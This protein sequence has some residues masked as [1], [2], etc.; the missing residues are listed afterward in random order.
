MPQKKKHMS[1]KK[2]YTPSKK[3]KVSFVKSKSKMKKMSSKKSVKTSS[4]RHV[5]YKKPSRFDAAMKRAYSGAKSGAD[6]GGKLFGPKGAVIGGA[7]GGFVN[8]AYGAI[9]GQGTYKIS[10][11]TLALPGQQVPSFEH[12]NGGVIIRHREYILDI[13]TTQN[14]QSLTYNINAG[15][16]TLFPWL[17]TIANQFELYEFKG[18][19]FDARTTSGVSVGTTNESLGY[20]SLV[21]DYN[22]NNPAITSKVQAMNYEFAVDG[23]PSA[24]QLLAVECKRKE[25]VMPDYFVSTGGVGQANTDQREFDLGLLNLI[26]GGSQ[27]GYVSGELWAS[28]EVVLRRPRIG[29]SGAGVGTFHAVN[30]TASVSAY[31]GATP[32]TQYNSTF[33]AILSVNT[34][35]F[36]QSIP[37]GNY[38]LYY[39]VIGSS[40]ASISTPTIAFTSGCK[41]LNLLN[42][43]TQ[44]FVGTSSTTGTFVALNLFFTITAPGAV[45]TFSNGTLPASIT[46]MDLIITQMNTSLTK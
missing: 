39:L 42:V 14:F 2:K 32:T 41:V 8:G 11:N 43:D 27:V 28:Y 23:P 20:I 7:L 22:A 36:P 13:S 45:L 25:G 1:S 12:F 3:K 21:C 30:T 16:S 4:K 31:F 10:S 19:I 17:S 40:T 38:Q 35:T 29:F 5:S 26:T 34:I 24:N 37:L 15:N 46:S 18:L 9:T 44:G 33:G 6:V